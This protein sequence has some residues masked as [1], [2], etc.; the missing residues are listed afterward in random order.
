MFETNLRIQRVVFKDSDFRQAHHVASWP[1]RN[2]L[3]SRDRNQKKVPTELKAMYDLK[4]RHG[5][6][7]VVEILN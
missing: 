1:N 5:S 4:S 3:W 6:E 2:Y 7:Y